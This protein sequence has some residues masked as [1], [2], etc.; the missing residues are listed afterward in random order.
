[1]PEILKIGNLMTIKLYELAAEN[2]ELRFS[3]FVW[4]TRMALLHKGLDFESHPWQFRDRTETD[5]KMVPAIYDGDTMMTDSWEIAKYLDAQYPDKPLLM[6]GSEGEAHALLVSNIC[7]TQVFGTAASMAL[8]P[9]SKLIDAE[10]AAYFVETREAKFGKK[11]SEINNDDQDAAKAALAKGMSVFEATLGASKFLGGDNPTYADYTLFGILKWIDVVAYRP[12]AEDSN[13]GKWF[14][15]LD[16][17]YD[18]NAAKAPT[19]RG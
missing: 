18:G 11:L 8:Y 4:R 15:T 19:V 2:K 14:D 13:I 3:P 10:S 9:V 12:V 17:L 5:H 1:M 6:N 7:N 16:G